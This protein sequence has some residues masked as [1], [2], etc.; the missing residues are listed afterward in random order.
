MSRL[1]K[2]CHGNVLSACFGAHST[3]ESSLDAITGVGGLSAQFLGD[4]HF[5]LRYFDSVFNRSGTPA[6][7][8]ALEAP[9]VRRKLQNVIEFPLELHELLNG[10]EVIPTPGHRYGAVCF[11]AETPRGPALFAG[12]SIDHTGYSW[13]ALSN[14][15]NRRTMLATLENLNGIECIAPLANSLIANSPCH[16]EIAS[17]SGRQQ[18]LNQLAANLHP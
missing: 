12:V 16:I 18:F 7:C 14:K 15:K 5:A 1:I 10:I 4:R 2:R 6:C 13:I 3:I 11:L 9:G 17:G 8:G